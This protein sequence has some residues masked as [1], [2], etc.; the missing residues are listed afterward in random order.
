MKIETFMKGGVKYF[1]LVREPG[2]VCSDPLAE[3]ERLKAAI[4]AFP[5]SRDTAG[6]HDFIRAV[7]DWKRG[8][9]GLVGEPNRDDSTS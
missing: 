9:D 8:V 1:A 6:P 5:D 3:L 2:D 7:L 4:R